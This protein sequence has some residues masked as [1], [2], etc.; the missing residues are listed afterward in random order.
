M[1]SF[2]TTKQITKNPQ[3]EIPRK[4]PDN[5]IAI[6]LH[7]HFTNN[8]GIDI[9]WRHGE[10]HR[11]DG[12]AATLESSTHAHSI[13]GMPIWA[14]NGKILTHQALLHHTRINK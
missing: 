12:P 8:N 14:I 7:G 6:Q 5:T 10:L 9:H 11:N 3:C 2:L 13:D 4:Q 1:N